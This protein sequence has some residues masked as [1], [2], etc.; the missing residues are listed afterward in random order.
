MQYIFLCSFDKQNLVHSAWKKNLDWERSY[1][2]II[3]L[4][5]SSYDL[6]P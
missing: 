1:S 4:H 5:V 3:K 2:F 6:S